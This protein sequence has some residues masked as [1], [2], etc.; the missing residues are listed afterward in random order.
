[1]KAEN[2]RLFSNA[3]LLTFRCQINTP[4]LTLA[5][6]LS[7]DVTVMKQ[8]SVRFRFNTLWKTEAAKNENKPKTQ[9]C[10]VN[11]FLSF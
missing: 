4:G 9:I 6:K 2:S 1:M 3:A 11:F 8:L 5:L 10:A 7:P